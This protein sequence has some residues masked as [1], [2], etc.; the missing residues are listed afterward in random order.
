M[1]NNPD[2]SNDSLIPPQPIPAGAA[3]FSKQVHGLLD[4]QPKDETTVT[5]AL[6]GLDEVLDI[7]AAKLYNMASMLVGEGEDSI[8]LV[9][10]AVAKAEVSECDD[11]VQGRKSSRLALCS[12]ALALLEKR[13][14]GSLAAPE[15]LEH[16][17]TCI[18]D[19]DLEAAGISTAELESMLAGP[20]KDRVRNWLASL[21]KE[22]RVVFVLR[23]VAGFTSEETAAMLAEHG[24]PR[25]QAWTADAVREVFRQ[26]L[27]SL[28][29]QLIQATATR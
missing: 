10:T 16:V 12:A 23:A 20:N 9:E 27:C 15:G 19:D 3:A 8:R 24:G 7:I 18:E 21:P 5:N 26:A 2:T 29:S 25:A 4:G 14:P 28:A 11:P 1:S 13:Q 22:L 6:A 17:A